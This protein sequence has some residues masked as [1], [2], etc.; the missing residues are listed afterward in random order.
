[1]DDF[2]VESGS[3]EGEFAGKRDSLLISIG[4][5]ASVDGAICGAY[6]CCRLIRSRQLVKL[7]TTL[8][9]LVYS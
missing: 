8:D 2:S 3:E 1:M 4:T 6:S 7:R 9:T 5:W